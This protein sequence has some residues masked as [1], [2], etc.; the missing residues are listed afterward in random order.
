MD[1][2][3]QRANQSV[4]GDNGDNEG[5]DHGYKL[6]PAGREHTEWEATPY[7]PFR[8]TSMLAT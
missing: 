5:M 8:L 2:G 6:R 1:L 4:E 7:W 3:Q